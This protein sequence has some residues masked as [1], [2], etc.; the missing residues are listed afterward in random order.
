[1]TIF[2]QR[3]QIFAGRGSATIKKIREVWREMGFF[4]PDSVLPN[5]LRT[6]IGT[7]ASLQRID[8]I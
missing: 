6:N 4:G 5:Q 8:R 1:V 7:F 3:K 2:C